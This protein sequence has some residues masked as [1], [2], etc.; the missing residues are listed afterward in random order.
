MAKSP[1][2]RDKEFMR[3]REAMDESA[4]FLAITT[5]GWLDDPLCWAQLG[6]AVMKDK[7]IYLLVEGGTIVPE[8]LRKCAQKIERFASPEDLEFAAKKLLQ[9]QLTGESDA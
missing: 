9:N 1:L 3:M 7:P 8:N 5:P 4:V 2:Y 6:Y